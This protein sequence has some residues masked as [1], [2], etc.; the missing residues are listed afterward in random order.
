MNAT[1]GE[2]SPLRAGGDAPRV[3]VGLGNPG[4]KY[5]RTRHNAGFQCVESLAR[6]H[7]LRFEQ[8][9]FKTSLAMGRIAGARVVLARPLTYMNLCGGAISSLVRWQR[10]GLDDLLVV[11]DDLDLPLGLVRLR[12][13]GGSGGHKGMASII[14]ALGT[15]EFPRLRIG[16]GR[17][18]E[19]DPADYVLHRFTY[20]E[21]IVM[22]PAYARALRAIE[23]YL[24]RGI[25]TAMNEFNG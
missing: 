19:D 4:S 5:T 25:E 21:M 12:A 24:P 10:L 17:S 11:Y 14:Q 22:E 1:C 20:D 6:A 3:I 2:H 18:L 9:R 13:S 15:R 7:G 16:I 8:T 23:R